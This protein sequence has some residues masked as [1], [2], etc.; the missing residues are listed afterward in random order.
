MKVS[1]QIFLYLKWLILYLYI[2]NIII[3]LENN[4]SVGLFV[5]SRRNKPILNLR[6]QNAYCELR[7]F[8]IDMRFDK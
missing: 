6:M 8:R 5:A 3:I 2:H 4:K 1:K 7:S